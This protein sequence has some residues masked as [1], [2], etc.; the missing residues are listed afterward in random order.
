VPLYVIIICIAILLDI[1]LTCKID[2]YLVGSYNDYLYNNSYNMQSCHA[3]REPV[4]FAASN[5]TVKWLIICSRAPTFSLSCNVPACTMSLTL[6]SRASLQE[7]HSLNFTTC[8]SATFLQYLLGWIP[9][10]SVRYSRL[11][12]TLVLGGEMCSCCNV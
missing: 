9:G 12:N 3:F 7:P 11:H 6:C 2:E 4:S 8:I 10:Y 5:P 1:V